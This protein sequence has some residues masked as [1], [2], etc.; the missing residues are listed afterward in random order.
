[1][2]WAA[3]AAPWLLLRSPSRR[4]W[5]WWRRVETL[6]VTRW[7]R[8]FA[9]CRLLFLVDKKKQKKNHLKLS[10]FCLISLQLHEE[11]ARSFAW[12]R[13][14]PKQKIIL[15]AL[16]NRDNG[17]DNVSP[18]LPRQIF[19]YEVQFSVWLYNFHTVAHQLTL[20][21]I[22]GSLPELLLF[23]SLRKRTHSDDTQSRE[24]TACLAYLLFVQLIAMD[25][26][27]AV[28]RWD[29]ISNNWISL[30]AAQTASPCLHLL[31]SCVCASVQRGAHQSATEQVWP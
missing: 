25:S 27:P 21:A 15:V 17:T 8:S 10:L 14:E 4:T 12:R 22:H 2:D 11:L 20:Q 24:S 7:R 19:K 13:T 23:N 6:N 9:I 5:W 28:F 29:E 26:F 30:P 18:F 31:Q 3:A 16:C 1:M